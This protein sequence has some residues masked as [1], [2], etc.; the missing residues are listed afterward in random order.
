MSKDV[1]QQIFILLIVF[2]LKHFLADFIFQHHYMLKKV[3]AG[4]DF[5]GPLALHCSVHALLTL[6]ICLLYNYKLAWLAAVDF[7]VHFLLDRF[8]S[9]PRYLGRFNDPTTSTFW[10]ILGADQM[11]HHLTHIAVI[12]YIVT[13]TWV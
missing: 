3:R 9:G 11:F 5:L 12:W 13:Q 8:R 7:G 2:Q 4:W 10:W 1:L 6:M